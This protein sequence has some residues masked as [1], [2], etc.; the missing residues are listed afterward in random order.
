MARQRFD[1]VQLE[2]I[3]AVVTVLK[4]PGGGLMSEGA[5]RLW[6]QMIDEALEGL[7]QDTYPA[8][9][10]EFLSLVHACAGRHGGMAVLAR[11][12]GLVA[13]ALG[14]QLQPLLDEWRAHETFEGRN[15]RF[16]R[17]ALQPRLPELAALV[18]EST[19]GRHVLPQYCATPWQAFVY[20]AGLNS[21]VG[22]LPPAMD[23]LERLAVSPLL[24]SSV[25]EL[26]AWNDHFADRWGLDKG[27]DGLRSL[28]GELQSA[29]RAARVPVAV[30]AHGAYDGTADTGPADG[31]QED[32]AE[33]PL[34][35]LYIRVAR[36]R[37]PQ[38]SS[39]RRIPRPPRYHVAACVKY[40][41]SPA[42]QR[43]PEAEPKGPV[44]GDELPASVAQLLAN[45]TVMWHNRAEN[46][47]L[48]FFLPL[49]LLTE[50]VEFWDRDPTRGFENPLLSTYRV[51]VH[52]L[53]RIQRREF[54]RAWRSRWTQW[55][56]NEAQR[57]EPGSNPE[58]GRRVVHECASEPALAIHH[59]L[60]R[61]DAAVGSDNDVVGMLLCEPPWDQGELGMQEV[62]LAL[63]LGVPVLMYQRDGAATPA[64]RTAMREALAEEGLAALPRRT[65]Q[66][67]TD[68]AAGRLFA[69]DPAT[70]RA[71]GMIWDDPEHL[72]DGGPSAP[73]T[74][75]GGTD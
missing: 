57:K 26:R 2:L 72:L 9:H 59:H 17:E 4:E 44:T 50:A 20:L 38:P 35:R 12:T 30:A 67:K 3:E 64:W 23:L 22:G 27:D 36:D 1:D 65:Q 47:A 19:S 62:S 55:R 40:A 61:L 41:D 28:R 69:H 32:E 46:V 18:A 15:W 8:P 10:L 43:Q 60:T 33:P 21:P 63:D 31:R 34:I 68:A 73:A 39:R 5:R 7:P 25:G 56:K 6:R 16:L 74:F 51:S 66:W 13:P 71:M 11:V 29:H 58:D 45:M 24:A 52:S 53:D 49:E 75:V 14:G 70:V 54:H 42:L 37:A 48:E